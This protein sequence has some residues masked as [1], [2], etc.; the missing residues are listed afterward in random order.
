MQIQKLI[1]AYSAAEQM[2]YTEYFNG[3]KIVRIERELP[4]EQASAL[5]SL[6][7]IIKP[8]YNS[9]AESERSLVDRFA[10]KDENGN[11]VVNGDIISFA[12]VED[13]TQ[14]DSALKELQET[15]VSVEGLPIKMPRPATVRCSWLE[16]LEGIVEF[17]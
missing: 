2:R 6:C 7:A 8:H 4:F 12:T 15:E 14:F 11:P 9:Y 10:K 3:Q 17:I 5:V 13:K 1:N 16:A